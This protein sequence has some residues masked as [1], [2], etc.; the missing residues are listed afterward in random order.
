MLR[1]SRAVSPAHRLRWRRARAPRGGVSPTYCRL[2]K[3]S[4]GASPGDRGLGAVQAP[5]LARPFRRRP[6]AGGPPL[7]PLAVP[8]V[9]APRAEPSRA[10]PSRTALP[11]PRGH[12]VPRVSDGAGGLPGAGAGAHR[13]HGAAGTGEQRCAAAGGDPADTGTA[14]TPGA[15]G[16]G[17]R[18]GSGTPVPPGLGELEA[19]WT[20]LG[21]RGRGPAGPGSPEPAGRE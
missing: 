20:A 16:A 17:V 18:R 6:V 1:A 13:D 15:V 19:G 7:P 10:P 14:E 3:P 12:H 5:A 2:Q 21:M 4:G 11:A 8:P 9:P